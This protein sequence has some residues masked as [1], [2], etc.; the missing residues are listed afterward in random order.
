MTNVDTRTLLFSD[1]EGSTR[2]AAAAGDDY[3]DILAT[4]RSLIREATSKHN[5][6]EQSTE[7]DSF[8]LLFA[9]ASDG[10]AAAVDAQLALTREAWPDGLEV[11]VRMGLHVG[12]IKWS[13]ED[14]V[15]LSI[16]EAARIMG[17]AHGGQVL[18]SSVIRDLTVDARPNDVSVR[19]LG[20]HKLKDFDDPMELVQICH[21]DLAADFPPP[22]TNAVVVNLPIPR[23]SFVGRDR[24]VRDVL[25]LL[26]A[27]RHVTLTG[28]GGSGKTRLA[29]E[30]A[31]LDTD[32][33]PDG[34]FFV[35]LAPLADSALVLSAVAA[36]V[37]A[38]GDPSDLE[39]MVLRYIGD[40]RA[41][42]VL[43]NCEHLIDACAD[44]VDVLLSRCPSIHILATSREALRIDGEQNFSV[45]S[46]HV[47]D[48]TSE[49][50]QLF[51][52]RA[53]SVKAD[54]VLTDANR[55]DVIAICRRLDGIPLAIELAAGRVD[56]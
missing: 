56:I 21:P 37:N 15:G 3:A 6:I 24:E 39:A 51:V 22:R 10:L 38:Q 48:D 26:A 32:N 9:S 43:D 19:N 20:P 23:T 14:V 18:V 47:D 41:L 53:R 16:H 31:V 27:G 36:S 1:I 40:R 55:H 12:E 34:V 30:V 54:F 45:P 29:L 44:V 17:A 50:V 8:F 13:D 49:A 35:D 7:G 33:H 42:I 4:H 46:L 2:L 5:G 28:V 25:A 52:S 11:R